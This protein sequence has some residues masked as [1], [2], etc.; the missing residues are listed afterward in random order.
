MKTTTP[1]TAPVSVVIPCFRCGKTIDRAVR[2]VA[3]QTRKP[4]EVILVDDASG[5]GTLEMLHR[6]AHE[7][8]GWVKVTARNENRGAAS[9]RNR[10][11]EMASHPYVAF[12]DADDAWHPRKIEIQYAYMAAHPETVLSGHAHRKLERDQEDPDWEVRECEALPVSRKALLLSNRFVTPAAMVKRDIPFRFA[13]GRRHM[14]DHLLWLEIVC[15]NMAVVRL[16]AELAAIFK[17]IYGTSGLS[18]QLWS[19]EL[20][21]LKNFRHLF[22]K[23][24]IT[25]I[26][27][28]GLS[29]YSMAKF[30]RRLVVSWGYRRWEK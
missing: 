14:E 11:W 12:L 1:N 15:A 5:D 16:T 19:M 3:R 8:E 24:R 27:W 18:A 21:D 6:L 17:P 28:L 26:Q 2:S 30:I 7:H 9:A 10:G 29:T 13:E 20:G 25:L 22:D 4:A 23:G